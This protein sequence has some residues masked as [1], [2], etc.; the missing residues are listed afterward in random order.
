M[1]VGNT[2]ASEHFEIGDSTIISAGKG[3]FTKVMIK[4]G[5]TIGHYT[6]IVLTDEEVN[7]P[8]YVESE[9]VLWVCKDCNI[10]GE[11]PKANYVRYINHHEEP[12]CRIVTSTR[13][14]KARMEAI[15]EIQPGQEIFIDYGPYYWE[16]FADCKTPAKPLQNP[17]YADI[18]V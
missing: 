15:Q 14:K 16:F 1:G 9:Y 5:D 2:W 11:G 4:P 12:N 13:W 18:S 8:P 7:S 3:L 6:G 17:I 10:V